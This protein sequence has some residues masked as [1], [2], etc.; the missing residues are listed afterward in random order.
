MLNIFRLISSKEVSLQPWFYTTSFLNITTKAVDS[1]PLPKQPIYVLLESRWLLTP[2]V[3]WN[4]LATRPERHFRNESKSSLSC[5]S[6][7][8][9]QTFTHFIHKCINSVTQWLKSSKIASFFSWDHFQQ[10]FSLELNIIIPLFKKRCCHIITSSIAAR[11][12]LSTVLILI[13]SPRPWYHAQSQ[14]I[15]GSC[16]TTI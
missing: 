13:P 12:F 6:S 8:L 15:V 5:W 9:V 4:I 2:S 10:I 1:I 3:W 7:V 14:L 16:V 11:F